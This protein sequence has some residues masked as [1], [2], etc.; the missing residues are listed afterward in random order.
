MLSMALDGRRLLRNPPTVTLIV[1]VAF[2]PAMAG[3]ESPP[4]VL[5]ATVSDDL[6]ASDDG[7]HPMASP[8]RERARRRRCWPSESGGVE[9]VDEVD[10]GLNEG[11]LQEAAA[12]KKQRAGVLRDDGLS[13]WGRGMMPPES[14]GIYWPRARG[15]GVE[16]ERGA[17]EFNGSLACVC[18]RG[19]AC[20]YVELARMG[21]PCEPGGRG[22]IS[23][24]RLLLF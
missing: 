19:Q 20:S 17:T 3:E 23:V 7:T 14:G 9:D 6:T 11:E 8:R 15:A 22:Y 13:R 21:M 16:R 10:G 2:T 24:S 12:R 5:L 1:A 4:A 18:V